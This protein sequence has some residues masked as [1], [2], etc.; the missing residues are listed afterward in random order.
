MFLSISVSGRRSIILPR[1]IGSERPSPGLARG[2]G[3][4]DN[5]GRLDCTWGGCKLECVE[6]DDPGE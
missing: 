5:D 4:R 2:G 6:V 3:V 1:L